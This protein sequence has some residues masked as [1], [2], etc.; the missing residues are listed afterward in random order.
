MLIF[1]DFEASSLFS[2]SWPIEIG[3]ARIEPDGTISQTG[4]LIRP[5]PAWS[6][7]AW[8]PESAEVHRI[9]RSALDDADPAADVARWATDAIGDAVLISDA[10]EFDQRWLDRLLATRPGAPTLRIQDFDN[11]AWT[12]FVESRAGISAALK[13][14]YD[15]R[16]RRR[17][18][19]R[20]AQDAADL[21]MSWRAGLRVLRRP[22]Q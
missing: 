19:H 12:V 10:P 15:T 5:D 2:D 13:A 7:T 1:I 16:A 14:V 17:T 20:A 21:A 6:E 22:G 3:L 18:T 9:P 4:R 11:A 8:S